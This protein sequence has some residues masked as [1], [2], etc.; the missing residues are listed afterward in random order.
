MPWLLGPRLI[1]HLGR[2]R[3][4]CTSALLQV[5][6]LGS[7]YF[8]ALNSMATPS[9][10]LGR[11]AVSSAYGVGLLEVGVLEADLAGWSAE[12]VQ[13]SAD[14]RVTCIRRIY[15]HTARL[16]VTLP[17]GI[18][19]SRPEKSHF[20]PVLKKGCRIHYPACLQNEHQL[21]AGFRNG[22][23]KS[24]GIP[25]GQVA[26]DRGSKSQHVDF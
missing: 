7:G 25:D 11:L 16:T 3:R 1:L 24:L 19:P 2:L 13:L 21:C 22:K 17:L 9:P 5:E 20:L 4:R 23:E 8:S 10:F 18:A 14:F 6:A 26:R 12:E 15:L